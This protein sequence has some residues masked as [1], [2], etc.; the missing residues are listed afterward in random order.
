MSEFAFPS[1]ETNE[2][3]LNPG[4]LLRDYFAAQAMAALI[5]EPPWMEG[6][7]ATVHALSGGFESTDDPCDRF[8]FAA[9]KMAD[10]MLRRSAALANTERKT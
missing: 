2:S 5:M 7:V 9:Y 3:H 6:G 1:V 4:M 10:A 8:A